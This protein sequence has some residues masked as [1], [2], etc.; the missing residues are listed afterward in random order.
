MKNKSWQNSILDQIRSKPRYCSLCL[1][2]VIAIIIIIPLCLVINNLYGDYLLQ[3][4][5]EEIRNNLL[6]YKVTLSNVINNRF[7][8]IKGLEAFVISNFDQQIDYR[9]FNSF[10]YSLY[11]SVD[12]IKNL[13]IAPDG[14]NKF[15][16]P[17]TDNEASLGHNLIQ[18][19]RVNVREDVKRA[20]RTGDITISGPYKL[21]QGGHGIILRKAIFNRDQF[22]GLVTMAIS[23]DS[24][25]QSV[26][27]TDEKVS[28]NIALRKDNRNF[29]GESRIFANNPVMLK[30]DLPDG[31]IDVA[32]IPKRGWQNSIRKRSGIFQINLIFISLLLLSLIYFISF[33]MAKIKELVNQQ[34]NRL[35]E[36]KERLEL[37]IESADLAVWDWDIDNNSLKADA[38]WSA[39]LGY[40][41]SELEPAMDKWEELLHQSDRDNFLN[42]LKSC[43]NNDTDYCELEY[44]MR[45]KTGD[46]KWIK[47]TGKVVNENQADN[48][49]RL[50]GVNQDIDDRKTKEE[51]I[52][53]LSF[54]DAMTGLYNRRYF[55]TEME[56]LDNSRKLPISIVIADL[57]ELKQIND[58]YGHKVGDQYI[59]Y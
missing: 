39:M 29:Y 58:T 28:L 24:I 42:T 23:M 54:H 41:Q 21:R 27:L 7:S 9:E 25:Y 4:K 57:D 18:D 22:W 50:V 3:Q 34:T 38:K 44:R 8:L 43:L 37:A 19:Q 47:T 56:R 16:F 1:V 59:T 17:L 49:Q 15:V 10:A 32:A 46:Y 11:N 36:T 45:T 13:I 30:V 35:N 26:G 55:E 33:R 48:P 14:I 20:I 5:R 31:K 52:K 51:N 6:S 53:F 40:D 2:I 12:G